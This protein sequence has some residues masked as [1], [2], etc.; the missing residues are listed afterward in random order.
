[1]HILIG[2]SWPFANG[3]LH[4]GHAAS[5]L[6]GDVIA[7]YHR[8]KGHQVVLVSGTDC[9][10]TPTDIKALQTGCSPKD[11]VDECHQDFVRAW[12]RI[13]FSFD[14]FNRTDDPYHKK[15]VQENFLQ[16][17]EK[18]LIYEKTE[19]Q[20]FCSNCQLFLADRY[21]EGEC[22]KCGGHTRGDECDACQSLLQP[23]EIKAPRCSICG[24]ATVYKETN[25]LY[26]AFSK[27][28]AD[29]AKLLQEKRDAWRENAVLFTERYL[30]EG[31][32]DRCCTRSLKWGIDVPLPGFEDKKIYVWCE[33]VVGYLTACCKYCE[34]KGLDWENYWKKDRQNKLYF[35][36]AKDN[37][38]FHTIIL[39]S[40]LI[41]LEDNYALPDV[42]VSDEYLNIEG[43]KLS[44][45]TGNYIALNDVLDRYPADVIRYYLLAND[46][47]KRDFNFTWEGF[48]NASNGELLGKW[49]NFINR[50]LVFIN[51]SFNGTL[52]NTKV[53][54]TIASKLQTL[55]EETGT[56]IDKG[57]VKEG[58]ALIFDFINYANKY[59]D[60][61]EPWQLFKTDE[62][63][64]NDVLY[65]AVNIIYNVNNLLKPYLPFSSEKVETYLKTSLNKWE[66]SPIRTVQ[67]L[68]DIQPLYT[69]YDKNVIAEEILKLKTDRAQS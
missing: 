11:I 48:I 37:I 6:S 17:Y 52:K 24:N 32:P 36:H 39:P 5:S 14:L 31:I 26:F 9:H 1:M 62:A 35:V 43:E 8:L 64:C 59:F 54:E 13:G 29:I 67:I 61:N 66:Y 34:A 63:A 57:D 53:D 58:L 23:E 15:I 47:N 33:N 38:P 69:R 49:G 28:Q 42:I 56:L 46:P 44:K 65:N 40:L 10:G 3:E 41:G 22:P 21:V 7:R 51:K 68:A 19:N 55:Y 2:I 50:T 60:E 12:E 4:I 20:H 25:H 16:Y 30:N 45:S 27:F 18:G